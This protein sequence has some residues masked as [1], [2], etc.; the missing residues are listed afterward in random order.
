MTSQK[1]AIGLVAVALFVGSMTA[2]A[3]D[4]SVGYEAYQ[5]GDYAT[6]LRI[7]RQLADQG[8]ASAQ[9][10]LGLIYDKGQGVPQ[11]YAVAVKWYRK[12]A[13]QGNASAQYNLGLMYLNGNGVTQDYGAAMRWYRKA[14]DQ[15]HADAQFNL[16]VMY[17]NG[18]GVTQDYVQAHMWYNL[19]AARGQKDAGKW[20][21]NL[22]E[23]MTP[24]Q[25][26]EAQKLAEEWKPKWTPKG[27]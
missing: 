12:A 8:D 22:A 2:H 11:D 20:R 21:D 3:A 1:I 10:N 17:G 7:F 4:F 14:V 27:K 15:G 26:A 5:C 25:I 18:W 24:A 13:D 19:A 23:K 16:G 6:A 9:F